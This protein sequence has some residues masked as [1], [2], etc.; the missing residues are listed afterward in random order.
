MGGTLDEWKGKIAF[1]RYYVREEPIFSEKK[2]GRKKMDG[3]KKLSQQELER[4]Q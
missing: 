3:S 4:M 1:R 2:K